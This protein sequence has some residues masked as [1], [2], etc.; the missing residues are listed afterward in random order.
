MHI[1]QNG[2]ELF[3]KF[4]SSESLRSKLKTLEVEPEDIKVFEPEEL[5]ERSAGD[6]SFLSWIGR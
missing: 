1:N 2:E 6:L 3:A 4:S 5:L